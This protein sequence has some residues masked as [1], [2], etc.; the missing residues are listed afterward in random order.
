MV[1]YHVESWDT[2]NVSCDSSWFSLD[3]GHHW[4]NL[5]GFLR[6]LF[7]VLSGLVRCILRV[8]SLHFDIVID[9]KVKDMSSNVLTCAFYSEHSYISFEEEW[10]LKGKKGKRR[11]KT[12]ESWRGQGSNLKIILSDSKGV[13]ISILLGT[14]SVHD[15][16]ML[17]RLCV[18][19]AFNTWTY[20]INF[21]PLAC[22][23][24]SA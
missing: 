13:G 19:Q 7:L 23:F 11:E 20:W 5:I 15:V 21:L 1:E 10:K 4:T 16:Q 22:Q 12:T 3:T 2:H 6:N 9:L 24:I 18:W 17:V 14:N 8:S